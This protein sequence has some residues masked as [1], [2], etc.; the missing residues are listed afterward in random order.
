MDVTISLFHILLF[1][2]VVNSI[3]EH[4][5]NKWFRKTKEQPTEFSFIST[6]YI[7]KWII[8]IGILF[9]ITL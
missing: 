8:T 6:M 2:I 9:K 1:L 5:F 3:L 4:L 7:M